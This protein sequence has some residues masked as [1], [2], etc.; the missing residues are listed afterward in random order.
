MKRCLII[1][2]GE[3]A[4]V[5]LTDPKDFVIACD[6]GYRHALRAGLTPDLIL[7]DFDSYSGPL[8]EGTQILRLPVEKDDTDTQYAVRWACEHGFDSVRLCCALG[9]SLDHLLANIQTLHFAVLHG[10]EASAGDARTELRVLAPGRWPIPE[11]KGWTLSVFSLTDSVEGL[12]IQGAK[13]SLEDARLTNAF[14]LGVSNAFRGDAEIC[15]HSGVAAV[16]LC[17]RED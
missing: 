12:S 4:D 11:R 9:G 8:P 2:G 15:F 13:Y 10:L 7:G 3:Y 16:L 6:S 17:R 14:P 5:G 1:A